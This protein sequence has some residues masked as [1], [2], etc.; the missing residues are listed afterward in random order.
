MNRHPFITLTGPSGSGKTTIV[1]ALQAQGFLEAVSTTTRAPRDGEIQ[2]VD[3]TFVTPD[4]FQKLVDADE[5][6]EIV[7]FSGNRYGITR[8]EIDQKTVL[9]PTLVVVDGNGAEQ[10]RDH[11]GDLLYRVYLDVSTSTAFT[12]MA[13]RGDDGEAIQK[14]LQHD[15]I[16]D[17]WKIGI[18]WDL[19][20]HNRDLGQT[21][22]TIQAFV[23][24][25]SPASV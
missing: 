9:G 1:R 13:E 24:E 15:V 11:Y 3:Y 8:S 7:E 17:E 10:I 21:V 4:R 22:R 6:L 20:I 5:F 2:E 18:D 23:L 16:F 25:G 19:L 12:R 14:R